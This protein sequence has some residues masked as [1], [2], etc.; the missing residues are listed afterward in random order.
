MLRFGYRIRAEISLSLSFD[1]LTQSLVPQNK[2]CGCHMVVKWRAVVG[3]LWSVA[4][5]PR[6]SQSSLDYLTCVTL[7]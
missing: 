7:T 2:V 5:R 4:M 6:K 1:L 3:W